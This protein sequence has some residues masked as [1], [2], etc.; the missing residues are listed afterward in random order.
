MTRITAVESITLDGVMQA[1]GGGLL[2]GRRTYEGFMRAWAGRDDNPFSP[3]A[4]RPPQVRRVDDAVRS[5]AVAELDA[6]R[7]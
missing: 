5:A 4:R 3:G 7:R 2:F 6:A 1:A